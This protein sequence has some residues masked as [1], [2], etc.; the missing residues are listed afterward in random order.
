MIFLFLLTALAQA[1][2]FQSYKGPAGHFVKPKDEA[3]SDATPK[4][5]RLPAGFTLSV[6]AK[7]LGDPRMMIALPDGRVLVSRPKKGDILALSD[8]D[9]DGV[10]DER[11]PFVTGKKRPHGL[12]FHDG[13]VYFVAMQEIFVMKP[14]EDPRLLVASLPDV[15]QHENRSLAIGP[16]NKLYVSIASTCN[17][18]DDPTEDVA[19][20]L[21]FG[22]DGKNKEVVARGLRDTIGF[23]WRPGGNELYGMDHGKDWHGDDM[24]PE[25]LNL[26][27]EGKHY[28]WPFCFENKRPDR[29]LTDDPE[30]GT[31]E[32]FCATTEAPA[33]TLAAHS[34]PLAFKFY[35]G[36][37]WPGFAGDALLALHGSWNRKNP[38]GYKVVRLRFQGGKPVKF[39]DFLT[40]FL[41][42]DGRSQFGRPAGLAFLAD[43][44]LLVS[45][46]SAGVI[47]RI[48]PPQK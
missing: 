44:S 8:T 29:L 7:D 31:K 11:T 22:L 38:V 21:R 9:G 37:T 39:D 14:G 5:L 23:D 34:A 12:A 35:R 19:T 2:Q 46:D 33:L 40:G 25:E 18:C 6:F 1:A 17:N 13:K 32:A 10:A 15:G 30:G 4:R 48:R 43:D 41:S 20:M 3:F 26:L 47:Y 16:D 28:G 24:P 27:R 45:D 42:K 36:K